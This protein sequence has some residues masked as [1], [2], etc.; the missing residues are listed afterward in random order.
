MLM[1]PGGKESCGEGSGRSPAFCPEAALR[2]GAW[3]ISTLAP[4]LPL[5]FFHLLLGPPLFRPNQK[6]RGT[7]VDDAVSSGQHLGHGAGC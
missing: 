4:S 2:E 6:P 7:G 5:S 1:E 3:G